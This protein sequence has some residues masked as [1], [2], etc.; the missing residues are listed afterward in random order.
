MSKAHVAHLLG[1]SGGIPSRKISDLGS[2]LVYSLG[3][4]S[5]VG[6]PTAKPTT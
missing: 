6:R 4:I 2:Y 1:D 5:K 3:E